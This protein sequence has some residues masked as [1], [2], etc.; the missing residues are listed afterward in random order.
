[1]V[2][3]GFFKI[4]GEEGESVSFTVE[5]EYNTRKS[6]DKRTRAHTAG[7]FVAVKPCGTVILVDELY[8]C[9]SISQVYGI[10]IE[11]L[12]NLS[13][14]KSITIMLY[15]DNCHLGEY[16]E[17]EKRA[18][19]NEVTKQFASIGKYIDKFHLKNHIGKRCVDKRDPYKIKRT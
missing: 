10:M 4:F 1:M 17:N 3:R 19:R 7:L 2:E 12:S 11:W 18:N 15:D 16:S 14:L 6:R 9:E 8:G 5:T 13:D